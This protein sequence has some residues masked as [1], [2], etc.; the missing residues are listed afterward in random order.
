[1]EIY[2]SNSGQL[3]KVSKA[4]NGRIIA[5]CGKETKSFEN[6]KQFN[7][8]LYNKGFHLAM[9][10]RATLFARRYEEAEEFL[11]LTDLILGNELAFQKNGAI[12]TCWFLAFKP[13]GMVEVKANTDFSYT[14]ELGYKAVTLNISDLIVIQGGI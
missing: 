7:V 8:H 13:N 9:T 6:E 4:Q 3:M 2:R 10:D 1:M 14:N 5:K 11:K 12:Y